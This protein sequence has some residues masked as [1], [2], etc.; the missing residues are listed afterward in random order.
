[1]HLDAQRGFGVADRDRAAGRVDGDG[2]GGGG[3]VVGV[4]RGV[5]P[6]GVLVPV[7]A[8]APGPDQGVIDDRRGRRDALAVVLAV[9]AIPV[10]HVQVLAA[11]ADRQDVLADVLVERPDPAEERVGAGNRDEPCSVENLDTGARSSMKRDCQ[12]GL[13]RAVCVKETGFLR[14]G[15]RSK[16]LWIPYGLSTSMHWYVNTISRNSRHWAQ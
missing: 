5:E 3:D 10:A 2:V 4:V 14:I 9:Q 1:R 6:V 15:Y 13:P 16:S 11:A 8:R 7:A 12:L